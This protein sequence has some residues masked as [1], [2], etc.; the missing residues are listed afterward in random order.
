MANNIIG[1]DLG[2]SMSVIAR[3]DE[4][5]SAVTIANRNGFPRTPSVIHYDDK[6]HKALV[7]EAA[8]MAAARYPDQVA[9]F[10]KR[11]IG[12]NVYSRP[13]NGRQFRPET[14]SAIILRKLKQDAQRV[15]GPISEAVI[16][17][18]AY[19][20][21]TRRRAT[22]DAGRIAGLEVL[23]I[24]NE[25]T[26]AALSYAALQ[27]Q[28]RAGGRQRFFEIPEGEITVLVYDLGGGTFDA[29]VVQLKSNRFRTLATNGDR[30]LGGKDW[31]DKIVDFVVQE[32]AAE[33]KISLAQID[34]K[35]R[36]GLRAHAEEAKILLSDFE[37]A[38]LSFIWNG[39][40]FHRQL[41]R[42]QFEQ[43]SADLLM[44]SRLTVEEVVAE[45]HLTWEQIDR[46][47]LVGGATR[48]PMVEA[49]L[50]DLT[51]KPPDKSLDVDQVVAQGAAIYAG[52]LAAR[53]GDPTVAMPESLRKE[54]REVEPIVPRN[55]HALGISAMAGPGRRVN[56]RLVPKNTE[57]PAAASRV[58]YTRRPDA[59][60]IHVKV[61]E[62]DATEA[63]HCIQIGRCSIADLPPGLP[64]RSPVQVRLSYDHS[65]CISVMALDMTHGTFAH[66]EI[67]RQQR[68]TEEGIQREKAFVESLD[69]P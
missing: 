44:R 34:E 2:T 45:A 36:I 56:V 55:A 68:L 24:I 12:R 22:L 69:I 42:R 23:D 52:I 41:T 58:F 25:P 37:T 54:L 48:M 10:V 4:T 15:V 62:G 11:E 46:V 20:D 57:L 14:L 28:Q 16:T 32:L 26:A 19:F 31:D 6:T 29:T 8:K 59:T 5:G 39:R 27:A 49:M 65:G 1:I 51:G 18:P 64:Q 30:E 3:L 67:E 21:E 35:A 50:T 9:M 60:E 53:S 61:L 43:L 17:V 40:Y 47:L 13:V 33:H 7:G 63:D 38:D 66:A